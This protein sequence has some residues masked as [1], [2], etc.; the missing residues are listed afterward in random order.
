MKH[1]WFV[2]VAGIRL[3]VPLWRLLTHDLSKFL[4]SELPHYG[5]Q[6]FGDRSEP[7]NFARCWLRHQNRNDHHWE[8]WIPRTA[9]NRDRPNM[10]A[11]GPIP[12]SADALNEMVADWLGASRAYEGVW[13]TG[14]WPWLEKNWGRIRLH[15]TTR[16]HVAAILR[17]CGL[18][19]DKLA[20]ELE[21]EGDRDG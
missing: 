7:D 2:A 19:L 3:G 15:P 20:E 14:S 12:M 13:P 16:E 21:E 18:N 8:Y 10:Q 5:R 1:K 4:P 9:H 17:G 11:D 6:F